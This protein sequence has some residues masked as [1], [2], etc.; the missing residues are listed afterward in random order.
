MTPVPDIRP[1]IL[2]RTSG[3]LWGGTSGLVLPLPNKAAYPEEYRH[4]PRLAYYSSL[5]NSLEIN[6]SFY[7]VPMRTT[8]EKWASIVPDDFRF[9]V[10]LGRHITHGKDFVFNL[11]DIDLFM[12]VADGIGLKKG[13]LLIQLPP[14]AR[15]NDHTIH[16]LEILLQRISLSDPSHSWKIAIEFR[17]SSWYM[18]AVFAMLDTFWVSIVLQDMPASAFATPNENG[19]VYIRFHGLAG[20]YKGSYPEPFL[21]AYAGRVK[22]WLTEGKDVYV[23]FNNTIGDAVGN[24]RTLVQLVA[25]A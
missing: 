22:N 7:K 17:H 12:E 5:F 25:M 23:Y 24:L 21:R 20:D 19:F 11:E 8:F 15:R 1:N 3:R 14:G 9:T 6:S 18:P 13:C 16:Q 4:R 10:K 2:P